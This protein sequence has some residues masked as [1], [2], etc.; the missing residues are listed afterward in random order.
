MTQK[1]Y[2]WFVTMVVFLTITLGGCKSE[3][4]DQILL[5]EDFSVLS[6]GPISPKVGP[7][8]EHHFY[9]SLIPQGNWTLTCFQ[10]RESDDIWRVL[11]VD[12]RKTMVQT[13]RSKVN[14][15]HPMIDAGDTIWRDYEVRVEMTP[16]EVKGRTGIAFRLNNDR[17]YYFFGMNDNKAV[18][19]KMQHG[20]GFR[21][22]NVTFLAS[23]P[24][25]WKAN[26]KYALKV[27]VQ[28]EN[29]TASIDEKALFTLSD[30]L[31]SNGKIALQADNPA[32][33]HSVKVVTTAREYE[34]IVRTRASIEEESAL[35]QSKNPK[36]VVWKKIATKGF[37]IGRSI[38]FGD[39]DGDNK[40]DML[41]GQLKDHSYPWNRFS[42]LGCLTAI[43][44][45]GKIL[46]QTGTPDLQSANQSNDVAF[47]I[48][49]IDGD[50]KN[51]VIYTKDCMLNI[52]EGATGKIKRSIKTPEKRQ[53]Q[54][55]MDYSLVPGEVIKVWDRILGDCLFF[56]DLRGVGQPRDIII[57]DMY[58]TFWV[59]DEKLNI[60][61]S[62]NCTTG[63]YPYARDIDKDGNEELFIGYSMFK[64]GPQPV[65]SW[66]G[67]VKDHCDGVAVVNLHG[68][69]D[70]DFTVINAA[71]DEGILFANTK[72]EIQKHLYLGH[73]QNPVT[74]NF[75]D[76]LPGLETITVNFWGNQGIFHFF[77]A[78]GKI[79]KDLEPIHYGSMCLPVNWTGKSEEFFLITPNVTQGGMFDG[80][81]RKVV[82][83][84]DD[85]HPDRCNAVLDVTGD[86]RDEIFVWDQDEIWIYTQQDNP[87]KG[88]I[89]KPLRNKLFNYSN[90]LSS[91]SEPGWTE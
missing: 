14:Y 15:T 8:T 55:A 25:E 34:R 61:W 9:K 5:D 73:V 88:A 77:D 65:W 53:E 21:K 49:D 3:R 56:C 39:L 52:A 87:L 42:E 32:Q 11:A 24:F 20:K 50:G 91:V 78:N 80:W 12:G 67:T 84:P 81:G 86:A 51:E 41:L 37:G 66:D 26:Q 7:E 44:M 35:L 18:V 71:S 54:K 85:G 45:E 57:K 38:R 59:L 82:A 17:C 27:I 46:W 47:Q 58:Q 72:G 76:D 36:L 89:Y 48:F 40:M 70:A 62:A 63:H 6:I 79:Y 28:G 19:L 22:E 69:Q 29:F 90:Y 30:A 31:F 10:N 74:A 60:R 68:S 64:D 1:N 43:T 13:Y 33:F 4:S 2:A 23:Q 16:L 75:R 83:F